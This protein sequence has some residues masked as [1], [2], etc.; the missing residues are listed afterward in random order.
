M[1]LHGAWRDALEEARRAGERF[2][3]PPGHPAAGSAFYRQAEL[4][5]LRGQ[6]AKAEEAYRQ[7]SRWGLRRAA[8]P[9]TLAT[10]T[11]TVIA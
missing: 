7:A 4:D 8:P 1:Q 5:R 2:S 6:F 9:P 11:P 10:F 3:Q